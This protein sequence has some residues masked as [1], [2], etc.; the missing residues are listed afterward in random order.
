M[1]WFYSSKVAMM[2][3]LETRYSSVVVHVDYKNPGI[4]NNPGNF[5]KKKSRATF[6]LYKWL[7]LEMSVNYGTSITIRNKP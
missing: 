4:K 2:P 6:R 3:S 5:S 7:I 1:D